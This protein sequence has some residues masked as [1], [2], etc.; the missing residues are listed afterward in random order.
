[1]HIK[2]K[3]YRTLTVILVAFALSACTKIVNPKPVADKAQEGNTSIPV[4]F[5][6]KLK[7]L[8]PECKYFLEHTK[9]VE[10]KN[11]ISC[12][13]RVLHESP[14]KGLVGYMITHTDFS[15]LS[16]PTLSKLT[17]LFVL[18]RARE[19]KIISKLIGL[20]A[21]TKN[22][23]I[24]LAADYGDEGE[25]QVIG[26][27]R[28][29]KTIELII[30]NNK[31]FYQSGGLYTGKT[32]V[33]ATDL[34]NITSTFDQWNICPKA[35]KL[36][37]KYNPGMRDIIDPVVGTPLRQLLS[38]FS[39]VGNNPEL[40]KILMTHKNINLQDEAKYGGNT[41]LHLLLKYSVTTSNPSLKANARDVIRAMINMGANINI[42]NKDGIT[43]RELI[44]KHPDLRHLL[45]TQN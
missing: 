19:H 22:I 36:L 1:M 3:Y 44:N 6:K 5:S 10:E 14:P 32:K 31:K 40:V 43:V 25:Q 16:K 2:N 35:V 20:G 26:N 42:K 18:L 11:I 29:C 37:T 23:S 12:F 21:Q 39:K 33:K 41:P 13:E 9:P 4:S 28:N 8:L 7:G 45:R 34:H 38:D 15:R 17:E 27:S 24:G 30:A